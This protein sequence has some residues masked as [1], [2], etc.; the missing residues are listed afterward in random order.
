M[1]NVRRGAAASLLAIALTGLSAPVAAETGFYQYPEVHGDTLVFASEGDLWRA[2]R[3]GGDAIR[4]T[5]HVEEEANPRISPDGTMVAFTAGYDSLGD[6]YVM[7][8]AGGAPKRLTFLGGLVKTV[9]WTPDGK[10]IF[11]SRRERGLFGEVLFTVDPA[12]GDPVAIPLFRATDGL[13]GSDGQTLFFTR[14]G[15]ASSGDNAAQYRG[16]NMGQLWRW[17]MGSDAE[18]VRMLADFDGPAPEGRN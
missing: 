7:P 1:K 3:G 12:G 15:I 9:G 13:V 16:G 5:N 4:L 18:A 6:I 8:L 14:R 11:M 17:Q 2:S 10:V